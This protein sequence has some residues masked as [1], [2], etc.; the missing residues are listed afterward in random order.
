MSATT[1]NDIFGQR[2]ERTLLTLPR[3]GQAGGRL[4]GDRGAVM[5]EYGLLIALVALMLVTLLLAM[6]GTLTEM[7]AAPT[8]TLNTVNNTATTP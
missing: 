1:D 5:A 4:H 8:E 6:T 3:M 2:Q 7:F